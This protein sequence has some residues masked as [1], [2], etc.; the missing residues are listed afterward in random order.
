MASPSNP[1]GLADLILFTSIHRAFLPRVTLGNYTIL[2]LGFK[3]VAPS[4]LTTKLLSSPPT[5]EKP[6]IPA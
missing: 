6:K 3:T 1:M 5:E 2:L 4:Y